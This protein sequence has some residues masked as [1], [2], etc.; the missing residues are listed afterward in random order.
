M[1]MLTSRVRRW[2]LSGLV[3]C[4]LVLIA[5]REFNST[6]PS[7]FARTVLAPVPVVVGLVPPNK[8][9]TAEKPVYEGTPLHLV[10]AL[11]AV[12]LCALIWSVSTYVLIALGERLLHGRA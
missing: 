3:G 5:A 7:L 1:L 11:A 12:P 4:S 9:G 8:I 6:A 10:A 2:G